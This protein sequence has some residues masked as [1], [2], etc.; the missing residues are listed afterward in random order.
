MDSLASVLGR[1][2]LAGLDLDL[3]DA[4]HFQ[5][6]SVKALLEG[7][8]DFGPLS[9]APGVRASD[10]DFVL[11]HKGRFLVIEFKRPDAQ[12][13]V[14]QSRLLQALADLSPKVTVWVVWGQPGAPEAMAI[15]PHH[16]RLS[17]P[18]QIDLDKLRELISGW[19]HGD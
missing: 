14:G 5:H 6:L 3:H 10:L 16:G 4:G 7:M 15:R 11:E 12:P 13:P 19:F 8:W 18:V 1:H 9:P 2:N 17:G